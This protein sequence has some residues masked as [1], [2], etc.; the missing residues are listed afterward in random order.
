MRRAA[1]TVAWFAYGGDR[2]DWRIP[3]WVS[4]LPG[5]MYVEW[6]KDWATYWR[7]QRQRGAA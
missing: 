4:N 2:D 7:F 5:F 6:I 1:E 3:P